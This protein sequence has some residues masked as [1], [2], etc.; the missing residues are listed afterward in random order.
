[1]ISRI[2]PSETERAAGALVPEVVEHA[3]GCF[4][5]DGALVVEDIVDPAVIVRARRAFDATYTQLCCEREDVRGVGERRF[6]ITINLEAPFDD[7]QLFANPYLLP[8]LSSA[9][10]ETLVLAAFGVVCSIPSAP[11]QTVHRDGGT[12]FG[13][14]IDHLLPTF[15]ITVAIPLLEM[16][17]VNGTTAL[18][19]GS[20]RDKSRNSK[21]E[22]IDPVVREGSVMLWDSRLRHGGTPNR[23]SLPRPLLYMTYC[24]PWFM[25]YGNFNKYNPKQKP[26]LASES[27]LS[28]LSEAYQR[29][30]RRCERAESPA[31]NT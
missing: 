19:L 20:H 10:D 28:G 22:N 1:M 15:A 26:L 8:I 2:I 30:L 31:V 17:E 3:S 27:F 5:K 21:Q 18:W 11:A 12:L 6:M 25:D 4:R 23:G 13:S 29:L 9:L 14:D 24:R 7:P 16:N